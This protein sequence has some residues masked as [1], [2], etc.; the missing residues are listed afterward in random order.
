MPALST[1][2]DPEQLQIAPALSILTPSK[3]TLAPSKPFRLESS[4]FVIVGKRNVIVTEV[5]EVHVFEEQWVLITRGVKFAFFFTESDGCFIQ[6]GTFFFSDVLI[7][8]ELSAM[9]ILI[10]I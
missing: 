9:T 5:R 1:S 6:G 10:S 7:F 8:F 3:L 4:K 2:E